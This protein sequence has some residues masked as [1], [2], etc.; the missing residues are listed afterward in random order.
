M[1]QSQWVRSAGLAQAI[2]RNIE[3]RQLHC[4]TAAAMPFFAGNL[5][6]ST[7]GRCR[8]LSQ[9]PSPILPRRSCA[10]TC[11][12]RPV[13]ARSKTCPRAWAEYPNAI[14]GDLE[15]RPATF[16][17][18]IHFDFSAF[19]RVFDGVG[20]EVHDDLLKARSIS[21]YVH[22]GRPIAAELNQLFLRQQ[23]H[24]L[25]SGRRQLAPRSS[26]VLSI[27]TSPASRR[28]MVNRLSTIRDIL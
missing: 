19:L 27:F 8:W 5:D 15:D 10:S 23:S 3:E 2:F 21:L 6:F 24:L 9:W 7:M 26:R 13:E 14:V 11:L 18:N 16:C 25:G 28:E 20:D 17:A 4:E 1:F 22:I 12:I